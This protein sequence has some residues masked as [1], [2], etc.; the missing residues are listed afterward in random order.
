MGFFDRFRK[1]K[2]QPVTEPDEIEKKYKCPNCDYETDNPHAMR[3]HKHKH[4]KAR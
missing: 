4:K 1:K 3:G 2:T